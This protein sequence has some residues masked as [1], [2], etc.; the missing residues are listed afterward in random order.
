[1]DDPVAMK[2]FNKLEYVPSIGD[3]VRN[4]SRAYFWPYAFL[5][6]RTALEYAAQSDLSS[7]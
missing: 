2:L 6:S 3:G 7:K 5:G 1:M 4:A